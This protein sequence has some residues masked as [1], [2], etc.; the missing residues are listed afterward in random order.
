MAR[1]VARKG[2]AARCNSRR[3][4]AATSRSA[5]WKAVPPPSLLDGGIKGLVQRCPRNLLT[6]YLQTRQP[7]ELAQCTD[8]IG[9]HGRAFVLPHET[10]HRIAADEEAPPER[11]IFQTDE[12]AENPFRLRGSLVGWRKNVAA[13]CVGNTRLILT[14]SSAFAGALIRL[15]GI[16]NGGLNLY[17]SSSIGK[18]TV[19]IVA[20]SVFGGRSY[21]Q[22]WRATANAIESI[23]ALHCDG[24]LILDEIAEMDSREIGGTVYMLGNGDGKARSTRTGQNRSRKK[25]ALVFVS[26]GEV[27]LAAHAA[28]GGARVRAG[29]ELRMVDVPAEVSPGTIFDTLHGHESGAA[30]ALHL[31]RQTEAHHGYAGRAWLQWCV[32]H[33]DELRDRLRSM[34]DELVK[35]WVPDASS[36]QVHRV[37]RRFALLA[38]G[39]ELATEAGITGWP[40]GT[41]TSGVEACFHAW[42]AQRQ[43]GIGHSEEAQMLAQVRR[44]IQ[45]NGA[46]RLTWW[47][48]ALDDRA[49]DKGLR[50]GFRRMLTAE[51][52]PINRDADHQREYGQTMHEADAEQTTVEHYIFPE[53]FESEV[54]E[55]FEPRAV[56]RVLRASGH[57]VVDKDGERTGRFA[58]KARLPGI[59]LARCY[60]LSASILGGTDD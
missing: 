52:R 14:L 55:G 25:W 36:G 40:A 35:R 46:G 41:A 24:L 31:A 17:G 21:V 23:A 8:R 43:G 56:L 2:A 15:A 16:G 19:L 53:V 38:A 34:V 6:L 32:D 49:P 57:L 50:A 4:R 28:E 10:V 45:L 12:T 13:P 30:L 26:A 18:T 33:I 11:I 44:W 5:F 59:G 51:G 42:L 7:A 29:Q 39:G 58:V 47:H 27:R 20:A 22:R 9:W 37:G 48:R 54:C 60:R 1:K 3:T